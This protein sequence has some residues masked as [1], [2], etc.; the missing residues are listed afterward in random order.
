[1]FYWRRSRWD[2]SGLGQPSASLLDPGRPTGCSNPVEYRLQFKRNFDADVLRRAAFGKT[3][4]PSVGGGGGRVPSKNASSVLLGRVRCFWSRLKEA[5]MSCRF[6]KL[7]SAVLLLGCIDSVAQDIQKPK[8]AEPPSSVANF[9]L[10]LEGPF[11]LCER[12]GD[13][14]VLVP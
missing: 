10:A 12:A 4:L 3:G 9:R 2:I 6:V 11:V 5:V 7:M 14:L 13:I 1:M 8:Q